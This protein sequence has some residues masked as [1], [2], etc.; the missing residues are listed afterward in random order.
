MGISSCI[1]LVVVQFDV[2]Q[3]L[4]CVIFLRYF[5]SLGVAVM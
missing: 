2:Q 5:L 1:D 3:G 4:G